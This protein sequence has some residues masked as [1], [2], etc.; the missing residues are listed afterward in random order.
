[1]ALIGMAVYC[2]QENNK[3]EYL[4]KTLL[5]L[6]KTVNFNNHRLVLSVNAYTERTQKLFHEY[7]N[8]FEV[9]YNERNIGTAEA[10]NKVWKQRVE[11]EHCVKMDDDVVIN[12]NGWLDLMEK[13]VRIEPTVGQVGLK[14]KDCI[15][16]PTTDGYYKSH[17]MMLPHNA[18]EPWIVVERVNHVMGTC[19]LHS[20]ALLD[21]V[22]FLMQPRLYGF[23]DALMSF[24]SQKAGFINVFIPHIDIDHIDPGTSNYQKW[25]EKSAGEDMSNY[26]SLLNQ[27]NSGKRSIYYNPFDSNEHL[28]RVLGD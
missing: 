7:G 27:F 26:S 28:Q 9:I 21:K 4:R 11:G 16:S 15:E 22:G 12:Y 23:D 18:G 14:R 25:K 19:V 2:T 13:V 8:M 5:S 3:D 17:L 20:S 10:I 24:R 1:M 6:S